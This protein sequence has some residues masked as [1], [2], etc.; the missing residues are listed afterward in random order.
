MK[1]GKPGA[2]STDLGQVE[3]VSVVGSY[4]D[5]Q[6]GSVWL[7]FISWSQDPKKGKVEWICIQCEI[8]PREAAC[9][10]TY[11]HRHTQ[12]HTYSAAL[13]CLYILLGRRLKFIF[14]ILL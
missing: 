7:L 4:R 10:L 9:M 1:E 3:R 11:R 2:S 8:L 14:K 13:I 12:T 6:L 5:I